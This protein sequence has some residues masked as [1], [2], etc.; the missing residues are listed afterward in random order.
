MRTKHFITL[1][2]SALL[3]ALFLAGP[4][5]AGQEKKLK[6]FT[7]TK[8]PRI[9]LVLSGG[10]AKGL[11]HVGILKIIEQSGLKVDY[12]TGTSMGSIVGGLYAAGYNADMLEKLVL[13]T[14]W[15]E[16]LADEISRRSVAINEKWDLDKY[17]G[18]LEISKK[19][20]ELPKG[21][22][23]GQ[24]LNSLLSRLT[25]HVQNIDDFERLPIP[26][27]CIATDIVSG[28]AYVLK[29]GSL[30]DALRASMA[31]PSIFTP[32]EIDGRLL[33]DGGVVRNLPVS[34]AREMGADIV[35][36]VDVGAPLFKKDELKSV[37]NIMDQ[38]VSL[39]GARS[40][41]EQQLLSDILLA[42]DIK[43]FSSSDFHRGKELIALGEH[44]A[45]LAL[46]ELR[47]L[48]ELQ[49]Q[50]PEEKRYPVEI[51]LPGKLRIASIDI[52]GLK[53]VSRS[54]VLGK[55]M[56]KPPKTITPAKLDE[57]VDRV[58]ASGFFE[59]VTYRI[60]PMDDGS[61]KLILSVTESS[62]VFLKFG[63]SYDLDMNAALLAN[64]TLR[65][66]AGQ[67]SKIALDARLSENPGVKASYFIH[68][69]VQRPGIGFGFQVYYDKYLIFT[70]N[71]GDVHSSFNYHNYGGNITAQA[72]LMQYLALGLGVQKDLTNIIAQIAPDDPKHRDI[73]AL[74]YFAYFQ[75]DNLDRTF[76]P[77]SGLQVYG[78]VK[79]LTDDL[80]WFKKNDSFKSFFKH[81]V[82]IKG[83]IP[84]HRML[85]IQL[86]I[87]GGFIQASEPFYFNFDIPGGW[88]I[89]RRNIPFIY[90]NYMGGLNTYTAGCFPFTGLN[91]MQISGKHMLVLD[92]AFQIEP[93]KD[94]FI[95]L[96]G[97]A[98]RVKETFKDL[99]RKR[100]TVIDQYYG[101]YVFRY[102]H[103]KNDIIY[104]Y[105]LTLGYNSI[106]GPI[107]VTLM[108]GSE[109]NKF[110]FHVNIGYRI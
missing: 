62:G 90:K 94:F 44:T 95:V 69:P 105:G 77:R 15:D 65:N 81:T 5:L 85:A 31:I 78:E 75:F 53:H 107:E 82:K 52:R 57:A 13:T 74:N 3:A 50:Y 22:K 47:A 89:Y 60:E 27:R 73:E 8:R 32:I 76:Y 106:I 14:D 11:A 109:S 26:F 6:A 43:G 61:L 7:F 96:R 72:I 87:T 45:R 108:R 35:I 25:L 83:S 93:V 68:T 28:E 36:A 38:S 33:V 2:V 66:M 100:N 97:N 79:Y 64:I 92:A 49:K 70:Y 42:P 41:R 103:L 9:G 29:K 21:Y 54:L 40:T 51:I 110:L 63:F 34:D 102:Q 37:L 4:H 86:G 46:P 84:V 67:G 10:G 24:K 17:L 80:K 56:I 58:Y 59:R 99:F 88:K 12:V 39:L 104:G 30:S 16:L 18:S 91:F 48:A 23:R 19:G 71:K 98:G 1:S 101:Y 55:L 20:I